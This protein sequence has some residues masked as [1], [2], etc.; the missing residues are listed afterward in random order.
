[1][2]FCK[3][4]G[5]VKNNLNGKQK[6]K[7][8]KK[9]KYSGN[10]KR[11]IRVSL[12]QVHHLHGEM[13]TKSK[14]TQNCLAQTEVKRIEEKEDLGVIEMMVHLDPYLT[15]EA[16]IVKVV[17]MAQ[18]IMTVVVGTVV[19]VASVLVGRLIRVSKKVACEKEGDLLLTGTC[20]ES[21]HPTTR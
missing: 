12:R 19:V 1:M 6:F 16:M 3:L 21:Q 14:K 18:E 15:I 8:R 20:L 13:P 7:E 10:W 5:L 4:S 17:H 2:Y 11:K 9:K